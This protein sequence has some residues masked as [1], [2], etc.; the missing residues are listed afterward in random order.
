MLI[1]FISSI[2]H[3]ISCALDVIERILALPSVKGPLDDATDGAHLVEH[4][5]GIFALE[6]LQFRFSVERTAAPAS[7]P[8]GGGERPFDIFARTSALL[9]KHYGEAYGDDDGG[10]FGGG[11]GDDAFDGGEWGSIAWDVDRS[12]KAVGGAS[13]GALASVGTPTLPPPRLS[14]KPAWMS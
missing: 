9:D 6:T 10:A 2:H 7:A 8:I 14:T 4:F 5:D 13:G 12:E 11:G 1:C 3:N